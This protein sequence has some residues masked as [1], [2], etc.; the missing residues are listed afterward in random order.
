LPRQRVRDG[1]LAGHPLAGGPVLGEA[2]IAQAPTCRLQL[3]DGARDSDDLARAVGAEPRALY[4]VLRLLASLDVFTE[5]APRSV[6]P[7]APWT[8]PA[9][10]GCRSS[11]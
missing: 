8:L 1:L 11:T 7:L 3:G 5:V 9:E 4:R 6:R 2:H 10:P